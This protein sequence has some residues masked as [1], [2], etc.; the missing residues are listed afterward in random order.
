MSVGNYVWLCGFPGGPRGE[1]TTCQFRRCQ[2]HSL[3]LWV[4]IEEG[5]AAHSSILAWR[6]PRTEGPG[7]L[8]LWGRIE[9]D[10]PERDHHHWPHHPKPPF[11]SH[12]SHPHPLA[13]ETRGLFPISMVL[14]YLEL[15]IGASLAALVRNLPAMQETWVQSLGQKDPVEK[16]RATH[17]SI[18]AWR[19]PWTEE[20][21]G[22]QSMESKRVAH[23]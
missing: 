21:G 1:E 4:G 23:D 13:P 17:S 20:P 22:L 9:S 12:C 6:I 3:D 14:P 8:G 11:P 10:S 2:R 7:G 15:Q 18:L 19:I 5:L 16:R